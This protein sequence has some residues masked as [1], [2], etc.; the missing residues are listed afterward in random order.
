MFDEHPLDDE[1]CYV[2]SVAARLV[3][4][5]PQTLRYYEREGLIEP[6][7]SA[8][9]VR[10]YSARD[11]ERLRRIVRLTAELGINLAGAEVVMNITERM[12]EMQEE[13]TRMQAEFQEELNRLRNLLAEHGIDLEIPSG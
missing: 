5:H 4:L 3:D 9:N 7:R 13:M 12:R 2:I 6:A 8:G 1:P 10:L 11:I